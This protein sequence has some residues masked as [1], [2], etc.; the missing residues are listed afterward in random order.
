[1]AN[2]NLRKNQG[3]TGVDISI[4]ILIIVIL[5]PIIGGIV[6]NISSSG[7]VMNQKSYAIN[8]ATN[9]LEVAKSID[10]IKYVYSKAEEEPED[11][12]T[13]SFIYFLNNKIQ[14][15]LSDAEIQTIDG[16][17]H[18][19]F[20]VK[21]QKQNHYK[22]IVD[23]IDYAQITSTP[24][25]KTNVVKEVKTNITYSVGNKL[26]NVEISTVITKY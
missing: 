8:I 14:N 16:N 17:E 4:S 18:I 12:E 6:Y 1:M 23:A 24:D 7:D 19:V 10:D 3:Y 26:K 21:D 13:N 2:M 5:I 9:V 25:P 11:S 22:V 20:T 15:R